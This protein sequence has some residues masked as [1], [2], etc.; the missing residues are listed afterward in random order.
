MSL[1]VL[2]K[3]EIHLPFLS[4]K[5]FSSFLYDI[6][7]SLINTKMTLQIVILKKKS[8]SLRHYYWTNKRTKIVKI[9]RI[10]L[11]ISKNK[12]R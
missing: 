12:I 3:K 11:G 9:Q 1:K 6:I 2:Q 8:K 7:S 4:N 5:S 10:Y